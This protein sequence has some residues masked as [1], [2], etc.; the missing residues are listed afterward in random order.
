[1]VAWP[2]TQEI[3]TGEL[4]RYAAFNSLRYVTP[5]FYKYKSERDR[6]REGERQRQRWILRRL[7]NVDGCHV[8]RTDHC[9]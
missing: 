9:G 2:F 6:D 1:M 5:S 3:G 8:T 4:E 7:M